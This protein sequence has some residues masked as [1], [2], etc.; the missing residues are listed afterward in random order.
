MTDEIRRPDVLRVNAWDGSAAPAQELPAS[1]PWAVRKH[2]SGREGRL[3]PAPAI[4]PR[5]WNHPDIGWGLILPEKEGLAPADLATGADAP[6]AIRKLLA[7]RADSPVLRYRPDLGS[8]HLRRYYA[9]RPAQDLSVQATPAGIRDGRIP[10]YL[11]IYASPDEVPWKLQYALN[12]SRYVGRLDL[13]GA[14]LDNYVAALRTD[15][16]GQSCDPC[17][18]VVWSVDHGSPDITSL[19]ARALGGKLYEAFEGDDQLVGR[20]L[21]RGGD[22]T[23]TKLAATL[24]ER[25]PALVVTTSHG[26]TGPAGD[27]SALKAKLGALVDAAY[28]PLGAEDLATWSPS[29]AIWYA[30]ACCSAGS[31]AASRYGDL[32][33]PDGPIGKVLAEAASAAGA[34]TAPLARDLL[35]RERPLR[36]FVGHVEP[37][38]DWTLRDP[39]NRQVVAHVLRTCLYPDLYRQGDLPTPIG[40]ALT[41]IY[42]EAGSFLGALDDDLRG[43][44]QNRS[45]AR[46]WALYRQLVAMD[47]QTLV[48][49]G[50]PTVSLPRLPPKPP[51]PPDG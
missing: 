11:L 25:K 50:D 28:E 45:G 10:R 3:A 35:G 43:I 51:K 12:M 38:F 7:D 18:P 20:A 33:P 39:A 9:D 6:E 48:I 23:R 47:R 16:S 29:G 49:L 30:H 41:E 40:H 1:T 21:L 34:M 24:L 44:D 14:A 5:Q 42:R 17:A 2:L 13:T 8:G 4:D 46:D 26:M 27:P 37:T 15:W 32:L 22:A 31:D 19:M 36:A